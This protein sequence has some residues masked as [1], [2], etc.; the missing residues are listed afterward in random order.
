MTAIAIR[1][2]KICLTRKAG[3]V[4][5]VDVAPDEPPNKMRWLRE[6]PVQ[7]VPIISKVSKTHCTGNHYTVVT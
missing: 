1:S 7:L 5:P 3:S 6:K 2:G 4:V